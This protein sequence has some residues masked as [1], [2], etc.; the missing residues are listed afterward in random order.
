MREILQSGFSELNLP[1]SDLQIE[2]FEKFYEMLSEK[3]KVMNLTAISGKTDTARLH[4]LDCAAVLNATDFRCKQV[5]DVGTGAGFPGMPLIIACPEIEKI[6][7]LDS[8]NKRISFLSECVEELDIQNA[9]PIHARAE[10]A[11]ELRENYDIAVS[12]AVARLNVLCEFSLPFVK[13]GGVFIAMKGPKATDELSE[14][15]TALEILGGEIL[16]EI[17]YKIPQ[18]DIVHTLVVIKKVRNT[19]EKYPRKFSAIKKSPL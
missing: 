13:L 9:E 19:P 6:T 2:K 18:T 14:A 11:I 5:I 4:F 12:R 1:I 16:E 3:N 15:A 7:L 17:E 8:L 10:D